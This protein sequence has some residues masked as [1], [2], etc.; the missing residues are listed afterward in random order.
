MTSRGSRPTTVKT[1]FL[2]FNVRRYHGKL[3]I[4]PSTAAIRR[5]RERLRTEMRSL[6]GANAGAVLP[7]MNPIVRGWSAY[8][9]TVVS[10]EVFTALDNYVWKLVYKWAKHSHPN[11]PRHWI[12]DRYFGRFNKTRQDRWVF[13][14][15]DS[16]AYLLKF[17]WTKIVRHQLVKST[18]SPDDPALTDYWARRRRTRTTPAA[19]QGHPASTA[20]AT[21]PLPTLRRFPAARR[22]SAA[23]PTRVGTMADHDP[24]GD[25]QAAHRL[26]GRRHAGP[27]SNPSHTRALSAATPR[28]RRKPAPTSARPR[29]PE[30]CLSRDA[31][32]AAS[33]VLRGPGAAMR[34][35]YPTGLWSRHD[36]GRHTGRTLNTIPHARRTA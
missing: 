19:G 1:D 11:K 12:V 15:R 16:G 6:R 23:K 32:K 5:I 33:P 30:A 36:T 28:R 17:S 14:D 18:A 35:G 26:P 21:R 31:V 3:L 22:G 9:R 34:R 2:G 20:G 27:P 24:K 10:S 8:Y 4:K 29:A 7:T 25:H 13:G